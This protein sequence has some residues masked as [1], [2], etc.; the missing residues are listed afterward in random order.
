MSDAKEQLSNEIFTLF[1]MPLYKTNI[2][3]K[4]TKQEQDEFDVII[5]ENLED[6]GVKE[7]GNIKQKRITIDKYLLNGTRKP[8]LAIQSFIEQHLKEFVTTVLG[9]NVDNASCNITQAW[10]NEYEPTASNPVHNHMNSIIS[11]VFYINCLKLPNNKADEIILLNN[12]H[13]MFR[14]I[15]LSI[16]H[17]TMFSAKAHSVSVVSGDLVL[18]PSSVRHSVDVNETTDQTRISLSFNTFM[19]GVLGE[20]DHTSELIIKQGK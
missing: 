7:S 16:T 6:R 17:P 8:L 12:G 1:P 15:E 5:S 3:R 4:L 11:G 18:F 10:L 2:G 13:E 19:F 14:D 20:Y 9:I